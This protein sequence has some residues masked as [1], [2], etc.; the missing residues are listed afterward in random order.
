MTDGPA[1]AAQ[2][3][4]LGAGLTALRTRST[5]WLAAAMLV[6][7]WG[8]TIRELAVAAPVAV[9]V[10]AAFVPELRSRAYRMG[11]A[12]VAVSGSFWLWRQHLDHGQAYEGHATLQRVVTLTI[13]AIITTSLLLS[14]VII[15]RARSWWTPLHRRARVVGALGALGVLA[16]QP[17]LAWRDHY[18]NY[19][20]IGDYLQGNG[21]NGDKLAIGFRPRVLPPSLWSLLV[22]VALSATVV[23]GALI[24]EALWT[25]LRSADAVG[26]LLT[27]HVAISAVSIVA[28]GVGNNGIFD[29]Y[30]WPLVFSAALLIARIEVS[31]D[32]PAATCRLGAVFLIGVLGITSVGLTYDSDAF[33]AA[34][35]RAATVLVSPATPA[36]TI[37]AGLE[38]VGT[39]PAG[40]PVAASANDPL[41][42]WWWGAYGG[43]RRCW[44]IAASAPPGIGRPAT[45]VFR[46]H[47]WWLSGE[48]LAYASC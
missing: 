34:R 8:F 17:A 38:W 48:L 46:W 42:S 21:M 44:V 2:L 22:A 33:D 12:L 32:P 14:P 6:G 7:F 31:D 47:S 28:A 13:A 10:G 30:L 19:W 23:L 40:N 37:D 29:R 16:V 1:L 4:C 39:H 15:W 27:A 25:R 3:A 18:K 35:W 26:W 9:A 45:R 41:Q 36:D 24:G 11:A 20:L 5:R 43:P